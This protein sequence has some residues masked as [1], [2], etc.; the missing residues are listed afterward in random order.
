MLDH[1][2]GFVVASASASSSSSS[3]SLSLAPSSSPLKKRKA[4][5]DADAERATDDDDLKR[6][7]QPHRSESEI[8]YAAWHE[9]VGLFFLGFLASLLT[10][11]SWDRYGL[12]MALHMDKERQSREH[13]AILEAQKHHLEEQLSSGQPP[14]FGL[15]RPQPVFAPA[16]LAQVSSTESKIMDQQTTIVGLTVLT[17]F[18]RVWFAP[19]VSRGRAA[20]RPVWVSSRRNTRTSLS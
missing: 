9:S 8:K 12:E 7:T 11:C 19:S 1:A 2:P 5:T 4:D 14:L 17:C 16:A 18:F 6:S 20:V 13:E 15:R 10:L 3:S